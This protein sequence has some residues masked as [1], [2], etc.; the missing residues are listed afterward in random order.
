MAEVVSLG[1]SILAFIT[2]AAKLSHATATL[3]GSI[4]D[5]PSDVQRVQTRLKDL[6]L[7]LAQIDRTRLRNPECV[8]DPAT[9]SYWSAKEAKLKSD[10]TEFGGFAA[11]LTTNI[12]KAKGRLKWFLSH[13]DRAKKNLELLSEDIDVLKT[14]LRIMES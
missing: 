8:G 14:L 2:I 11:Q 3:Y 7:I 1:A 4:K 6:E 13:G 5:A 9:E 12:G 10:F